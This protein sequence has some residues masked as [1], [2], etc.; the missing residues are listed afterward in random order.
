MRLLPRKRRRRAFVDLLPLDVAGEAAGTPPLYLRRFEIALLRRELQEAGVLDGLARRGYADVDLTIERE[1]DEHRLF[2]LPRGSRVRLIDLR[3]AEAVIL[4]PELLPGEGA[5][6]Y[7][8]SIHWLSMQDPRAR[9]TPERP[10]LPGQ[11]HPGLGLARE[12]ILRIHAWAAAWGKDA[13]VNFPEYYHN[14]VF[15]SELYRFASPVREGRFEAL[16]RDLASMS[17]AQASRAVDSGKVLDA[18]SGRRL[19][20]EPGEMITPLTDRVRTAL[21]SERYVSAVGAARETARFRL[22]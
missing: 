21:G 18:A 5:A 8:L 9:F 15:Y 17:V 1:E 20:W 11:R 16:R 4:S 12:L 13:L 14:A 6:L 19:L 7:V 2:V 10:R 3:L 22:R